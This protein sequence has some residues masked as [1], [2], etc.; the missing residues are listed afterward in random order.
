[1]IKDPPCEVCKEFYEKRDIKPVC[2]GFKCGKGEVEPLL[3]ENGEAIFVLGRVLNQ[4][5]FIGIDGTPVDLDFQ[6][7][8]FIL[9]LYGIEDPKECFEKVLKAWHHI[10]AINRAK[11]RAKSTGK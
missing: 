10:A 11:Q 3:E 5:V 6:S 2:G 8:K 4:A 9:D 7:V 1:M